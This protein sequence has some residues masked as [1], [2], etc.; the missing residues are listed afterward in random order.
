MN[1]LSRIIFLL[2]FLLTLLFFQYFRFDANYISYLFLI[3][4]LFLGF[5]FGVAMHEL[6]HLVFGLLS[7]Y[8]FTSYKFLCFKIYKKEKIKFTFE[9]CFLSIPGQC[10]MKPRNRNYF[11]YNI[12][13]LVFTYLLTIV[14]L[15]IFFL[16]NDA[17]V[18]QIF[19]GVFVVNLVLGILNSLYSKEGINDISNIIRCRKEPEF[20]EGM[21]YQ[22]DI[23][24]NVTIDNKFKS[25][26]NPSDDVRSLYSNISIWR[27]KYYKA[28]NEKNINQMDK[29]YNLIK[30]NYRKI[31]IAFLKL[32]CLNIILNHDFIINQNINLIKRRVNNI[33]K[34]DKIIYKKLKYDYLIIDFYEVGI[35]NKEYYDVS[36]LNKLLVHKPE[37]LFEKINNDIL[38]KLKRI[39]NAYVENEYALKN[40]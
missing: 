23:I 28:Y 4:G 34:V 19:Y 39:Y 38:N 13:G 18:I 31:R 25:R 21:L 17:I 37:D 8:K 29:Y 40:K 24:A 27:I 12:G 26:Y 20:L 3:P 14:S 7:G 33:S 6:G 32:S 30:N 10:L 5:I 9:K 11:L 16:N 15:I 1:K 35:I 36:K 22:L 2:L